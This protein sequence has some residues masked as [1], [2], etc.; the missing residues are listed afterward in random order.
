MR[1]KHKDL[2]AT[3]TRTKVT[4][5]TGIEAVAGTKTAYIQPRDA[6]SYGVPGV[7]G[8]ERVRGSRC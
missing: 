3:Q 5:L 7:L 8:D 2:R 6:R 1:C 4:V